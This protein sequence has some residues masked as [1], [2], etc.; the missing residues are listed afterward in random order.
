MLHYDIQD[1]I[2][3]P[4]EQVWALL[5]DAAQFPSWNQGVRQIQGTISSGQKITVHTTISTQA[6]PVKVS[7]ME[8]LRRMVWTGGMPLGLF[9]GERTFELEPH[10]ESS[11]MFYMKEEFSGPM[12][13]F[14][15]R[16]IPDLTPS[17]R[18][19]VEG[20]KHALES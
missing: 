12:L 13:V 2:H 19:Y 6:F 3:A 11:T 20:L 9:R 5:T 16:T 1:I 10:G 8:P 18:L 15:K 7:V 17:F 14:M 4:P